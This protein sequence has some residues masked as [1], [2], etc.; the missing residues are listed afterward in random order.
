MTQN[1]I[2]SG[3]WKY[4]KHPQIQAETVY[5]IMN[6]TGNYKHMGALAN[7][8]PNTNLEHEDI[9]LLG[10][11]RI[12]KSIYM[13]ITHVINTKYRPIDTDLTK[14]GLLSPAGAGTND[15]SVNIVDSQLVDNI[16]KYE[17]FMGLI[18]T[19]YVNEITRTGVNITQDFEA[20]DIK[21]FV[22]TPAALGL[23]TAVLTTTDPTDS[24]W[25]GIS[26]GPDPIKINGN[27]ENTGRIQYTGAWGLAKLRPNGTTTVKYQGP[28]SLR[29]GVEIQLWLGDVQTLYGSYLKTYNPIFLQYQI[30]PNV[31]F[32]FDSVRLFGYSRS[33]DAGGTEYQTEN[34]V[35]MA[36]SD[37]EVYGTTY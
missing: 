32:E 37:A 20:S 24:P 2:P 10:K 4:R 35:G 9:P 15:E 28:S 11:F 36:D 12:W 16:E 21:D 5:G 31:R 29:Y 7:I 3:P 22:T 19:N 13:G 27:L 23:G 34:Y 8:T 18:T 25:T 1:F 26:A 6:A 17:A 33:V 30:T 14:R